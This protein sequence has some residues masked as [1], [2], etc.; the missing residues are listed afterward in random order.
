MKRNFDP[1]AQLIPVRQLP[2]EEVAAILVQELS[3]VESLKQ[4]LQQTCVLSPRFRQQVLHDGVALE[5]DVVL[6]SPKDVSMVV[7]PLLRHTAEQ[8]DEL[9]ELFAWK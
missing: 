1:S 6:D 5:D 2:G 8:A 4:H 7:L 9:L 3:N